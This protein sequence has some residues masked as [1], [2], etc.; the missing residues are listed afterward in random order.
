MPK[1]TPWGFYGRYGFLPVAGAADV[2]SDGNHKEVDGPATDM[3]IK[4]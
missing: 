4:D 1:K 2:H 3:N